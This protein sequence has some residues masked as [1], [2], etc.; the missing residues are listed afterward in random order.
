MIPKVA[1]QTSR[2][3]RVFTG[4]L[5]SYF[6]TKT[7]VQGTQKYMFKLI[8]IEINA[9]LGAQTILI[10]TYAHLMDL[11]VGEMGF[12]FC[13]KHSLFVPRTQVRDSGRAHGPSCY[14]MP[15]FSVI[16]NKKLS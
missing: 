11:G 1:T 9:I 13:G 10:W 5:F 8:G 7:Y 6:S 14:I 16:M 2:K 15:P 3:I 12:I 4:K